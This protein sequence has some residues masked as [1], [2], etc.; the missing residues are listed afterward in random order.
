VGV[1]RLLLLRHANAEEALGRADIDR[2]L[3]PRGRA[4]ALEAAHSIARAELVCE[5]LIGSP[6]LRA[7]ETA[8]IVAAELQLGDALQ[9]EPALY[10]GN[11]EALLGPLRRCADSVNTLLIVGHNPGLSELAQSFNRNAAPIE[12]CTAG[13]CLVTLAARMR[14][15][16]LAPRHASGLTLLR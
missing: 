6:A 1:K 5:A 2:P 16:E 11:P 7:R 12:L 4:E 3:S 14:W 10:L 8:L 15:R 13:L 9:F